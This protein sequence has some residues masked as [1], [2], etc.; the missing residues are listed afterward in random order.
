MNEKRFD[1]CG[2]C[3]PILREFRMNDYRF[4]KGCNDCDVKCVSWETAQKNDKALRRRDNE[5]N[6]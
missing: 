4:W 6:D 2:C 1:Y 3:T 5:R